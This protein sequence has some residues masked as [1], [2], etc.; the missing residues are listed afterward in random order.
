MRSRIIRR[1]PNSKYER[2]YRKRRSKRKGFSKYSRKFKDGYINL[3]RR[4]FN[5]GKFYRKRRGK[6]N[7]E[8]LDKELDN[9]FKKNEVKEN[10]TKP[11]EDK[12]EVDKQE[13]V[14]VKCENNIINTAI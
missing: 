5:N 12:M 7:G 13:K 10:E 1:F 11:T 3:R 8:K 14:E 9:Y 2:D 6:L 4:R